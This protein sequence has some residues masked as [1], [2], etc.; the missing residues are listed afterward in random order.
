MAGSIVSDLGRATSLMDLNL[1]L[2]R[3]AGRIPTQLFQLTRLVSLSI[4]NNAD[5]SGRIPTAF[6]GSFPD[7]CKNII[8]LLF[9]LFSIA[10]RASSCV[11]T[12][13]YP[14]LC[15][16]AILLLNGNGFTGQIPSELG[17]LTKLSTLWLHDN[18][19]GGSVPSDLGRLSSL[20]SVR[21]EGNTQ[22][23]G[24]IP[25]EVCDLRSDSLSV[26][27]IDCP[28]RDEAPICPIPSCC[29]SCVRQT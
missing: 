11:L 13:V 21:I 5:I 7:L 17:A 8:V 18:N 24:R 27:T 6:G 15:T 9:F 4:E 1:G 23:T 20:E 22:L 28:T 19:L 10:L 3:F 14:C 12:Q 16:T 29:T 26:F 2:N 25:S